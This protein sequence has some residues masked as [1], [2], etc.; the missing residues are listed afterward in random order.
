MR[1]QKVVSLYSDGEL[2][3]P[4]PM[5]LQSVHKWPLT[6]NLYMHSSVFYVVGGMVCVFKSLFVVKE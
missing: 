3:D 2:L 6:A 1:L 4:L 5:N